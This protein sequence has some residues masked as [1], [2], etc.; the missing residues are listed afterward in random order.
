[1]RFASTTMLLIQ[2]SR[3][4]DVSLKNFPLLV[5]L[6]DGLNGFSY[7]QVKSS[8]ASSFKYCYV[9]LPYRLMSGTLTVESSGSPLINCG[10]KG[11][12]NSQCTG[13]I[14]K[15]SPSYATNGSAWSDFIWLPT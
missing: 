4:S 15:Y 7:N 12:Q 2:A 11:V 3:L 5:R 14:L 13:A 10:Y 1:M 8:K 9:E 6:R